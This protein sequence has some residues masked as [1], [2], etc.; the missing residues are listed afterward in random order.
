VAKYGETT[1]SATDLIIAL[2]R[3]Y[4]Q[5][6]VPADTLEEILHAVA[7][8]LGVELQVNALPT[9]LTVAVGPGTA[10]RLVILRLEPGRLNL[11]K[12]AL[13]NVVY[14]GLVGRAIDVGTTL[15]EIASIDAN[16]RPRPP[17]VT[18]VA[19]AL[20]SLGASVLLG[21]GLR[22][23]QV[24]TLVGV[25][26]GAIGAAADRYDPVN[27]M[28]EVIAA[29]VATLVVAGYERLVGP[30]ALY[31]TI[32][33][34]VVQLLP[35]FT[36]TTALHELAS[37]HLVAG[38]ARLG[39][40]LVTLL[41]LGCGF[42]LAL[43]IVGTAM[44]PEPNFEPVHSPGLL[45]L[46]AAVIMAVAISIILRARARDFG[47]V[48]ASC[49]VAVVTSR[50]FGALPGHQVAAFGS[51][52]IVGVLTNV[53]SRYLRIPQAVMLIPGILVL[54]PGSLSYES[55]L[56]IF[57][58]DLTNAVNLGVGAVLTSILIV[59]GTL[60]SQLLIRPLPRLGASPN[61]SLGR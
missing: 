48:C 31:I 8:S 61:P 47:W 39:G 12:L 4:H 50:I 24:S 16:V 32:V 52:F 11:R 29:F 54:V 60:L 33:A 59:A 27:R 35:G 2:G 36:L 7:V 14:Q 3:A 43:A 6:G 23:V 51:A 30:V 26:I 42:A 37:R 21:G 20:L 38:T 55:I 56:A 40:V 28:F 1:A 25:A 44:L 46:P 41:S 17:V 58:T 5:A 10:Q 57:R 19:Y 22:E 34:G 15:T 53:A 45:V 18:I 49:V 9:S 13:L